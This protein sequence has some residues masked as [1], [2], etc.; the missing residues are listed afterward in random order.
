MAI[1]MLSVGVPLQVYIL[2][3]SFSSR[4]L[5]LSGVLTVRACDIPDW[6]SSVEMRTTFP[7]SSITSSSVRKPAAYN[8]SSFVSRISL[9]SFSI[10]IFI[11]FVYKDRYLPFLK[12]LLLPSVNYYLKNEDFLQLAE[13]LS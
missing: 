12:C 9:S 2:C 8:P 4:I 5:I 13:G 7:N 3:F 10:T 1:L 11:M 6:L